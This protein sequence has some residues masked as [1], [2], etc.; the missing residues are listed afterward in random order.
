MMFGVAWWIVVWLGAYFAV[1]WPLIWGTRRLRTSTPLADGAGVRV[2]VVVSARNEERDLP[3]CIGSL[4]SLDYPHDLLEII[5]VDD[6]SDDA[7]GRMIDDTAREHSHVRALH[8]RE[9]P[10]NGLQAKARGLAHGMARA[11]GEWVLITDADATVPTGWVRHLLGGV[12]P[13]T[14][15]VG[16]AIMVE[17]DRWWSVPERMAWAFLQ[18]FSLGLAGWGRPIVC[19][20]P[21]MG[22]RRETY[23]RAGGLEQ[24]PF[25]VAEDLA[26]FLMVRRAKEQVLMGYSADTLAMVQAVPTA[27]HL[28]SQ[29]RRWIAGGAEQGWGYAIGVWLAVL[30]GVGIA[31]F[32]LVGWLLSGPLWA[33]FMAVKLATEWVLLRLQQRRLGLPHHARYLGVLQLYMLVAL[34]FLPTSFLFSRKIQWLGDGYQVR[35]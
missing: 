33:A 7:T 25:R 18:V 26:L 6:L 16:G 8:T 4:L 13:S 17:T 30:W 15:M 23:Q 24:A 28:F 5:L 19:V 31:V 29:H 10:D 2:S 20:G 3:R 21:N 27:R 22:I 35:Y 11:T 14:G 12:S 34:A 9:L 32:M 1:F